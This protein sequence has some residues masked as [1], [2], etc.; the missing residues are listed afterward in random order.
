LSQIIQEDS[1]SRR[2]KPVVVNNK[3]NEDGGD[4]SDGEENAEASNDSSGDD[5]YLSEEPVARRRSTR[6]KTQERKQVAKPGKSAPSGRRTSSRATK[7]TSSMAEPTDAAFLTK[8]A[9]RDTMEDDSEEDSPPPKKRNARGS[10]GAVKDSLATFGSPQKSPARRH[11]KARHSIHKQSDDGDDDDV[12]SDSQSSSES[13][14]DESDDQEPLKIHR[15]LASRTE[16]LSTWR[17]ICK[18]MQTSEVESGSRWFQEEGSGSDDG[19]VFEERFLV[20]WKD[21]SHLHCS[22]ET[23]ADLESFTEGQAK[24]YLS[25]F[26]RKMENGVLL[27]ADER[28]DG[29]YFDPGWT[30]IDRIL[31]IELPEG[32]F[33]ALT[34]ENESKTTPSDYGIIL[35]RSHEKFDEGTGRQFLIKWCNMPYSEGSWEFERDLVMSDFDYKDD[36]RAFIRRNTKPTKSS[37]KELLKEGE[38]ERRRLYKI[39]GEKSTIDETTKETAVNEYKQ[40]LQGQAFKNDGQLR[41]YQAEGVAWMMSNYVNSRSCILADEMVSTVAALTTSHMASLKSH[42]F[43][44][45]RVLARRYRQLRQ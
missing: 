34:L 12:L 42:D 39:F 33:P 15:I 32:D 41:D 31:E 20:K 19:D 26:F 29:D 38:K 23:Q 28:C 2:R 43:V 7:F 37:M 25:T 45:F 3:S 27:S 4:A 9:P 44:A 13:E 22:W 5:D 35:D 11:A 40:E 30:Q 6:T 1:K 8:R 16:T 24:T 18:T 17:E 21:L 14:E 36:V 10:R